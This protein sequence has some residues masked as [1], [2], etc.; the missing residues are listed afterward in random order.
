MN[1][2]YLNQT[3]PPPTGQ[4]KSLTLLWVFLA[5]MGC[6]LLVCVV[7][8]GYFFLRFLLADL[9]PTT[10][11]IDPTQP[12]TPRLTSTPVKIPTVSTE[13]DMQGAIETLKTLSEAVT[14]NNNPLDLARRLQGKTNIPETLPGPAPDFKIGDEKSFWITNGDTDKNSQVQAKLAYST[15]HLHFWIQTGVKYNA[16]DLKKLCELFESK[17]YPTNREF[18]GSEWTPGIDND[19]HLYV[20]LSKGLGSRVAGYFSSS[21]SVPPAARQYSN[22]HET[23]M[24]NAESFTDLSDDFVYTVLAHEFQHM[25]HWY[26]DRNEESW[27]NEGFSELA[28]FLNGYDVGGHDYAFAG[29]PDL[30]LND[31][32]N[33]KNATLPHYGASFLFVDYFLDRFG[34]KATQAVVSHPQNGLDSIDEVLKTLNTRDPAT[35]QPVTANDV[36]VDWTLTNFLKDKTVGDG[37]YVY[38]NYKNAPMVKETETVKTCPTN[39]LTR[40]VNQYGADYIRIT[41]RGTYTLSFQGN[42]EIGVLPVGAHSGKYAFWSNKGD[43]SDIT[44][45]QT[46]DFSNI[47]DSVKLSY[48]TWYDL[49]EHYDFVYLVAS[50]DGGTTWEMIRTPGSTDDN[51]SGNNYGWGYNNQTKKWVQETVD[52]SKYAGKKVTLRFEYVTDAAVNGE[53]FMIDDIEIPQLN[54]KNDFEKDNGGWEAGGFVR[55]QNRLPQTFRVSLIQ[56]SKPRSVQYLTVNPD[57]SLSLPLDLSGDVILVISGTTEFTRLP[58]TY[59]ISLQK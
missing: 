30:Q 35:N 49:E 1:S 24:M 50:T 28:A 34:A 41:C 15:P 31:W 46:F 25:I 48:W 37:R 20:L 13:I 7:S 19:P 56:N 45:T 58:G 2:P 12:N 29:K 26:Q 3:P 14:P 22:G 40:T 57:Q 9:P 33:D 43:E 47:K 36:F 52:L 27:L 51:I 18:F 23:F 38:N 5:A 39:N 17:I 54:Y 8:S 6:L 32:P 55:M 4:G 42:R 10:E 59:T 53:G 21:D 44:L 16:D 11:P